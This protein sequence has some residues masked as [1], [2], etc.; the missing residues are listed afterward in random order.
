MHKNCA[1]SP[2][3]CLN[4]ENLKVHLQKKKKNCKKLQY[5]STGHKSRVHSLITG[6]SASTGDPV[7]SGRQRN[8]PKEILPWVKDHFCNW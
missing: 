6:G 2:H 1:W 8:P 7:G 4:T 5:T 3:L